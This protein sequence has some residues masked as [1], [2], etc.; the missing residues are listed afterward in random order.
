MTAI[1]IGTDL[2]TQIICKRAVTKMKLRVKRK[3]SCPR[4]VKRSNQDAVISSLPE[5]PFP[6]LD[7]NL[8]LLLD[9]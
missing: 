8:P 1:R 4:K 6:Q 2:R 3:K 7:L 9:T 5:S